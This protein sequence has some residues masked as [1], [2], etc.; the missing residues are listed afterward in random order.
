MFGHCGITDSLYIGF[1]V[2]G[3][4]GLTVL[5]LQCIR[6]C[7]YYVFMVCGVLVCY[8]RIV[9]GIRVI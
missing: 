8:V 3:N 4:Y 1:R 9:Y 2:I 6:V 5:K 7:V